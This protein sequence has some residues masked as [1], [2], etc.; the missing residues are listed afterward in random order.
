MALPTQQRG[1]WG[2]SLGFILAASGSAVG[3]GNIWRFPYITGENGGGAFVLIYLLCVV[4]IGIPLLFNEIAM[5]RLTGKNPIGAFQNLKPK[6]AWVITGLLCILACFF[7]MSYYSVI[8]GWTI[9]YIYTTLFNIETDFHTFIATPEYVIPLLAIFIVL[10][11]LIVVGGVEKG[12]ERWSKVLMPVLLFLI[13]VVIVRSVTLDGAMEGIKYYLIPDFGK[14]NGKVVLAALGQAFFS[15]SVGW[16]L[17]ITYGSYLPKTQNIVSAGVWIAFADTSVALLGG[18]MIFPAVFAL[19]LSPAQGPTLTFEVLPKVF[20]A[21]PFGNIVGA[22]FF[23]LLMIAALTSSIS[24]LEVP[25]SYFVDEHKTKRKYAAWIVGGLAFVFGLPSALSQ[26]CSETLTKMSFL[27]K[28]SFLD[29]M[30]HIWGTSVITII[31]LLLS[32]FAG[33]A[34]DTKKIVFELNIGAPVFGKPLFGKITLSH[35]WVFFIKVICPLVIGLVLLN[36]FGIF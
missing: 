36:L 29:I 13:L 26:G 23:L 16:G 35:I 28:T 25:V 12:I 3:L 27:G 17:M 10:T 31:C 22:L 6:S 7:V 21:M 8:A 11:I 19:G 9:G 14:I 32:L 24:M 2:S 1:Q 15:M 20:E 33:W 4:L 18:L 34:I 30:D 5:G